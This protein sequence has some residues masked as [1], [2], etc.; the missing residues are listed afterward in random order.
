MPKFVP[1][2]AFKAAVDP[3]VAKRM[4]EKAAAK[5]LKKAATKKVA[6]KKQGVLGTGDLRDFRLDQNQRS[7]STT[8]G[9]TCPFAFVARPGGMQVDAAHSSGC[10]I[11][12][13]QGYCRLLCAPLGGI[14]NFAI[15]YSAS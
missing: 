6:K 15:A 14:A 3:K 13:D 1:G 9:V 10:L 5:A 4:A 7:K 12:A 8:L 11:A 2:A